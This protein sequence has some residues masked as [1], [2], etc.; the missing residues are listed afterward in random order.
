MRRLALSSA[1]INGF[2]AKNF[3]AIVGPKL[4]GVRGDVYL[5]FSP[6]RY[7][8]AHFTPSFAR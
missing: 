3:A 5:E 4:A 6:S 1:C 2:G 8:T 7:P